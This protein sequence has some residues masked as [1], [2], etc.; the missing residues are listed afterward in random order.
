MSSESEFDKK[1][2]AEESKLHR[3]NRAIRLRNL[4]L[5]VLVVLALLLA[6]VAYRL[7]MDNHRLAV[8][9]AQYGAEQAKE[10]KDI[11]QE[12]GE[13]LCKAG[14]VRKTEAAKTTCEKVEAAASDPAQPPTPVPAPIV[15]AI[16]PTAEE[17]RI[18][19]A[20]YC[21][22]HRCQG[23]DGRTPT[24]EDVARAVAE[25]CADGSCRGPQG[26]AGENAPAITSDQLVV[27]VATYCSTGVCVG[28][29]GKDGTNGADGQP[30]APP[31]AEQIAEAVANYCTTTGACKGAD[32]TVP[33][34]PGPQGESGRG[35]ASAYCGDDG[36]WLITYTDGATQDGGQCRSTIIGVRP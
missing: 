11:A 26:P 18:A 23:A 34:P 8:A 13:N 2:E 3:T 24:P 19:V 12:V 1:I 32:S 27:A 16:G 9:N 6:M 35:I 10:K 4:L 33:G 36:R 30:G 14:E 15:Q 25:K 29:A 21:S 22:S 17:L 20:N 5:V 7:A 28:Q 31:T